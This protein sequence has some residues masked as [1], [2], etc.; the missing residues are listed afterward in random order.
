MPVTCS[1]CGEA[2]PRDPALEVR[3]PTRHAPVGVKCQRPSGHPCA[4]SPLAGPGRN[5]R[6]IPAA[7]SEGSQRPASYGTAA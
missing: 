3:C 7:M 6:R 1:E 2:W 4:L 5:G